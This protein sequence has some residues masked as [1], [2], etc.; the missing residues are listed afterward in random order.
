MRFILCLLAGCSSAPQTE[1]TSQETE[2]PPPINAAV[3]LLDVQGGALPE[4]IEVTSALET[5]TLDANGSGSLQ[6]GGSSQFY[7]EVKA[8]DFYTHHLTGM[9]GQDD[10][11][12]VSFFASRDVGELMYGL[13][14]LEEDPE[15]GILI[16]ALDNPDLSPAVDAA[17]DIDASHDGAFVTTNFGVKFSNVVGTGGFVA[18][19][20]VAT[21]DTTI[22]VTPPEGKNCQ[23]HPAGGDGATVTI[24]SDQATVAFFVCD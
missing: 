24:K 23:F 11:D 4:G 16:V 3:Q 8:E 19:P 21:G 13:L 10:F 2:N 7:L 20:N 6:V 18:F 17:A 12:L 9:A 15:K 5:V 14:E 1:D 22:S